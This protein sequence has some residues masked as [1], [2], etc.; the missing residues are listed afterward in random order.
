[1]RAAVNQI[2]KSPQFSQVLQ[3]LQLCHASGPSNVA[4]APT[5][6]S[7]PSTTITS[8]PLSSSSTV[9]AP[10]PISIDL[11]IIDANHQSPAC[12][13]HFP[14]SRIKE[15]ANACAQGWVD[16]IGYCVVDEEHEET[17]IDTADGADSASL[18]LEAK[19]KPSKVQLLTSRVSTPHQI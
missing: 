6:R 17:Q 11:D 4:A 19:L 5:S 7:H 8:P 14:L 12:L 18:C 15:H 13:L 1:M 10:A 9:A 3:H 2:L 16:P